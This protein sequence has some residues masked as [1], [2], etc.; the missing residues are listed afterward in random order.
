MQ[1]E[2][3][4]LTNGQKV[5]PPR[6]ATAKKLRDKAISQVEAHA[7]AEFLVAADKAIRLAALKFSEFI[8]DDVWDFMPNVRTEDNRAMGAAIKRAAREG[9]IS[10]SDHYIPSEQRQC[11]GNP[12]RVWQS[13]V[14]GQ[15]AS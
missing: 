11:H 7:T 15:K 4:D 10:P 2:L 1:F 6:K 12:R 14:Y 5:S 3:F 9:V 8:V 13:N